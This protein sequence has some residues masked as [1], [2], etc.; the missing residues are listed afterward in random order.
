MTLSSIVTV[1]LV[2]ACRK[3]M[4]KKTVSR[5]NIAGKTTSGHLNSVNSIDEEVNNIR[6]DD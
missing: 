3:C 4:R 5:I 6:I 1:L 2:L